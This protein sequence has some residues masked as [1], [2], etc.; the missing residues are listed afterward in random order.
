[1]W[2][3]VQ[4]N[5]EIYIYKYPIISVLFGEKT[6]FFFQNCLCTFVQINCSNMCGSISGLYSVDLFVYL[7]ASIT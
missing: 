6:I 2:Y 7:Y 5:F 4:I 1:M 3:E